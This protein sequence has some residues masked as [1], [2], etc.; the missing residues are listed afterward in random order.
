MFNDEKKRRFNTIMDCKRFLAKILNE[1]KSK[2]L[3][4][5]EIKQLRALI[6][7]IN[8]LV[9]ILKT[10]DIEKKLQELEAKYELFSKK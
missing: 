5:N 3:N 6:Y 2:K 4:D 9:D 8:C 10:T 1:A 7:C